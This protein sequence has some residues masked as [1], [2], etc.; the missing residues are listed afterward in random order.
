[1]SRAYLHRL[2]KM[3]MRVSARYDYRRDSEGISTHAGAKLKAP[4]VAICDHNKAR[5]LAIAPAPDLQ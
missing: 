2:R 3:L 1:M 5:L 4:L